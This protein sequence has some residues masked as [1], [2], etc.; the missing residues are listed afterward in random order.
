MKHQKTRSKIGVPK[1][2]TQE[3]VTEDQE[4][5]D[6]FVLRDLREGFMEKVMAQNMRGGKTNEKAA[7][8]SPYCEPEMVN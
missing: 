6:P 7:F 8:G 2:G 4:N 1:K 3:N 5:K